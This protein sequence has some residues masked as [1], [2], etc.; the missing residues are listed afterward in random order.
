MGGR[1]SRETVRGTERR[2]SQR[3]RERGGGELIMIHLPSSSCYSSSGATYFI[4]V[5]AKPHYIMLHLLEGEKKE[6]KRKKT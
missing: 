2:D 1:D 4:F 6:K 5:Y 3:E